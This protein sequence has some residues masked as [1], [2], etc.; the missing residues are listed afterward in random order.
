MHA[1]KRGPK[2]GK[3][4]GSYICHERPGLH[5]MITIRDVRWPAGRSNVAPGLS[6][7]ILSVIDLL[8]NRSATARSVVYC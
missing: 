5:W 7:L 2:S 3:Q 4:N 6:A 1:R 8:R